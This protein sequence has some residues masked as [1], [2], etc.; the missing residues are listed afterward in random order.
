MLINYFII[1]RMGYVQ[2]LSFKFKFGGTYSSDIEVSPEASIL[3]FVEGG[4]L[5]APE[6]AEE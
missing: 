6:I 1:D 4:I 5:S 2:V 3:R